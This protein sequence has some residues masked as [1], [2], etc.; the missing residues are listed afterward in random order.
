MAEADL[1]ELAAFGFGE[2]RAEG[3][4]EAL[5]GLL[6]ERLGQQ[7][8]LAAALDRVERVLRLGVEGERQ[9]KILFTILVV[10][11]SSRA[12]LSHRR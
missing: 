1:L 11:L 10:E 2:R 8:D 5:L 9:V 4:A 7:Q 12:A 3:E 6:V